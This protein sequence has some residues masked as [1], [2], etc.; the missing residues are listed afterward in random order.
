M[1]QNIF[2]VWQDYIQVT[3][4]IGPLLTDTTDYLG[5]TNIWTGQNTW[6]TAWGLEHHV[7]LNQNY[8][9]KIYWWMLFE[10]LLQLPLGK[11]FISHLKLLFP[12]KVQIKTT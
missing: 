11:S 2:S 10:L 8:Q 9:D 12:E 1:V 5:K 7:K 3:Q 6:P 4:Y